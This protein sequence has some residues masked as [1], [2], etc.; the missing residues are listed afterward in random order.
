MWSHLQPLVQPLEASTRLEP[1]LLEGLSA[2][3][4]IGRWDIDE[5]QVF[6]RMAHRW[7][8]P[9]VSQCLV[10]LAGDSTL[11]EAEVPEVSIP[12][13]DGLLVFPSTVSV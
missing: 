3:A 1:F 9:V 8:E 11:M 10:T 4:P 13:W 5:K 6:F 12:N 2:D 7:N